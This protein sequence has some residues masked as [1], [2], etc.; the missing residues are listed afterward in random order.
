MGHATACKQKTNLTYGK[1]GFKSRLIALFSAFGM[2]PCMSFAFKKRWKAN[3]EGD[4]QEHAVN[5]PR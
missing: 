1:C 2:F 5:V 3:L 4:G